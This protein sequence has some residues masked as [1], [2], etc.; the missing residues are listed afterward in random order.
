MANITLYLEYMEYM[1]QTFGTKASISLASSGSTGG[2]RTE[3][4]STNEF[5][6]HR[7]KDSVCLVSSSN[8][9]SLLCRSI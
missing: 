2:L 8:Q 4:N 1:D 6:V 9:L 3:V 7:K 5:N